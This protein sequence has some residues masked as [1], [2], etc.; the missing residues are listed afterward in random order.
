MARDESFGFGARRKSR[1][2]YLSCYFMPQEPAL[3]RRIGRAQ[4]DPGEWLPGTATPRM[5]RVITLYVYGDGPFVGPFCRARRVIY[6]GNHATPP[7]AQGISKARADLD[8]HAA[9]LPPMNS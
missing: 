5:Q 2:A 3:P 8:A 6:R 1:G 4:A 7:A 9:R